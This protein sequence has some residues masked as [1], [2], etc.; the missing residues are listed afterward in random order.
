MLENEETVPIHTAENEFEEMAVCAALDEVGIKYI[1]QEFEDHAYDGLF[2]RTLGHS[3]ILVLQ[4]DV[5]KALQVIRPV[6]ER[7]RA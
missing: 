2:T 1:V 7:F 3:R 6:V 4:R 5:E